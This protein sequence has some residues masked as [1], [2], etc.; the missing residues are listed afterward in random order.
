MKSNGNEG[1]VISFQYDKESPEKFFGL[2]HDGRGLTRYVRADSIDFVRSY[3][4]A[5]GEV[6]LPAM[7]L[8]TSEGAK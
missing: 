3:V 6:I 4:L 2:Y 8:L 1:Q 7:F 5:P